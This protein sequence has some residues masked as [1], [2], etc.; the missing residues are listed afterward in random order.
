MIIPQP[1]KIAVVGSA[2]YNPNHKPMGEYIDSCD[3]VM[4]FNNY[5]TKGHEKY[6]GSKTTIW[7]YFANTWFKS[8]R[9]IEPVDQ[10]WPVCQFGKTIGDHLRK[11]ARLRGAKLYEIPED[12][13]GELK[14]LLGHN[15]PSTGLVGLFVILKK[16]KFESNEPNM[17]KIYVQGMGKTIN[18]LQ[19]HYY[20]KNKAVGQKHDAQKE[21]SLIQKWKSEGLI[22]P[23]IK[24]L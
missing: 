1:I 10:V 3:V 15:F 11:D 9:A 7:S 18:G 16:Y 8:Q 12:Y 14:Q 23:N 6:V 22:W 4:R 24:L 20:S 17:S 2:P 13:I 5:S 21:N 19:L